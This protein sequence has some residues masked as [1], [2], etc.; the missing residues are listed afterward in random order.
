[1]TEGN[2]EGMTQDNTL[3][4]EDGFA[5]YDDY[6]GPEPTLVIDDPA[7]PVTLHGDLV[8]LTRD[9][10]YVP[11]HLDESGTL[12]FFAPVDHSDRPEFD[13]PALHLSYIRATETD[14]GRLVYNQQPVMPLSS[15]TETPFPRQTLDLMLMDGDL[16]NAQ[17]LAYQ[18]AQSHG[19]AFP[20]P[21]ALPA[22]NKGVDYR[23]ETGIEEEDRP[24]IE[25]V[26]AWREGSQDREARLTIASYGM[27]PELE[28]DLREL[29]DVRENEGLQAA[30]TLAEGMAVASGT[31]H[32]GRDDPRLFTDGPPD[33]FTTTLE[34]ER[35]EAQFIRE[36]G[37]EDT[38]PLTPVTI[39]L[40][41]QVDQFREQFAD[42]A[43]RLLE[44]IDPTVNYSFE[45]MAADPWTMELTADKW[46]LEN[47][48][49]VGH[50]GQTLKTYSLESF[51]W[52]REIEREVAAID[53]EN[54]HRTYQDEGLEAA[55]RR[56][57][58]IAVANRELKA[59]RA[60]GRLFTD[61]PP[62]RFMT[63]RELELL[64]LE[65]VQVGEPIRDITNDE[66]AEL[67]AVR[68]SDAD[69]PEP[70][71][72]DDL[73]AQQGDR[74]ESEPE[75]HYWQT[76][77]RP[78][79]TPDGEPLG[80]ALFVTEFPQ[81]PPDFDDY[82]DENGMDDSVYPTE[83]RTLEM[84]HFADETDAAK[85]DAEFR[86]Y[87]VP[88]LL[89]GPELAPEVAKLEGLSGEWE[90]MDYRGIV[91][92]MSGNRTVVRE[93]DDWHLHNPNAER[94]IEDRLDQSQL[95]IDI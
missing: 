66:T 24:A 69:T 2:T 74:V 63:T 14:D 77:Y 60:D 46:W 34:R 11:N 58:G 1:M 51:E 4:G 76:H 90:D 48:G 16:D 85:F 83:A 9:G 17:E 91:D 61:G 73:V 28:V 78:V 59:D 18:T 89:D 80:T 49:Q 3:F 43:Y 12:H 35:A 21:E 10:M 54:L 40:E 70:G 93:A 53:V 39:E 29:N 71:S 56:A 79:E 15:L 19:L 64:G 42:S 95:E 81:L 68:V 13:A 33:P 5:A 44:P 82:I 38:R 87:L 32:D 75:R 36:Y 88:G 31:L 55:M 62:D 67:P 22:L 20:E 72:W 94:D 7:L 92:Y 37:D 57:E 41:T 86:G 84:A 30:M 8:P 45:V 27:Q 50:E 6:A 52:E 25:A 47:D 23:F 26:K 65:D